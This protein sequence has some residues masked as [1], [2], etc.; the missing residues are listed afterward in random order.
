MTG[1]TLVVTALQY[2]AEP[3]ALATSKVGILVGVAIGVILL[4]VLIT[5]SLVIFTR[6]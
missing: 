4:I 6:K 5:V 1:Q 3:E 2:Q